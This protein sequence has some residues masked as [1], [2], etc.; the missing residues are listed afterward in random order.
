V[1]TNRPVLYASTKGN[2]K[3]QLQHKHCQS[4]DDTVLWITLL[5]I[6]QHSCC[7][8]DCAYHHVTVLSIMWQHESCDSMSD[9]A[10]AWHW[11]CCHINDVTVAWSTVLSHDVDSTNTSTRALSHDATV[12]Y[13][14]VKFVLNIICKI[15]CRNTCC[16]QQTYSSNFVFKQAI[17]TRFSIWTGEW[18]IE[19]LVY[20]YIEKKVLSKSHEKPVHPF[21]QLESSAPC[22]RDPPPGAVLWERYGKCA[23]RRVAEIGC[24]RMHR[25]RV[26]KPFAVALEWTEF[27]WKKKKKN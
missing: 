13:K 18:T 21:L 2:Q 22:F 10:V 17:F 7:A 6:A 20:I 25:A 19:L 16:H 23:W 24:K 27:K 5:S 12:P 15:N 26:S 4:S 8:C 3:T 1:C 14:K 11:Q 9:S